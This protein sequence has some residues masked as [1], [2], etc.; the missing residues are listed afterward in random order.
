[1]RILKSKL[2]TIILS[3]ESR[4][5]R[6]FDWFVLILIM[7]SVVLFSIETIEQNKP[8][9]NAELFFWFEALIISLFTLEYILRIWVADSKTGYIFSFWGMIDFV[10]IF[11]FYLSLFM[12]DGSLSLETIR[13]LRLLRLFKIINLVRYTSAVE[14]LKLTFLIAKDELFIFGAISLV[15]LYISALGIYYFEHS[16]QPTKFSS[17]V[18]SLWW[19]VATLTTV[20]YGDVYPITIGGKL[21]TFVI[22]MIGLG[23]IAAPAGIVSSALTQARLVQKKQKA[24]DKP[25]ERDSIGSETN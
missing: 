15:L 9:F 10:A 3:S 20:G 23:I 1:M 16:A 22:L 7:S 18:D 6:L 4:S 12:P 21:F 24:T 11:P 14:R 25:I 2:K 17:I 19:A 5:G 13:I 8:G